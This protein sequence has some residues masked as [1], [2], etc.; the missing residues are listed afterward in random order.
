MVCF[1]HRVPEKSPLK[2][3]KSVSEYFGSKPVERSARKS[4][5]RKEVIT[6]NL[7]MHNSP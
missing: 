7:L 1:V 3:V 5:K 6:F 2:M 4:Q